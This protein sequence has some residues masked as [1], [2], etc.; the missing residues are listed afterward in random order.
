MFSNIQN[1]VSLGQI[2]ELITAKIGLEQ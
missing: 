2:Y 1:V